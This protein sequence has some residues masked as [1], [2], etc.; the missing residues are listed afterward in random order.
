LHVRPLLFVACFAWVAC[1]ASL[2]AARSG[3][4]MV[5]GRV[6][7]L[8]PQAF[9]SLG[10][11]YL[12]GIEAGWVAPV[13]KKRLAISIDL[14]F[15]NPAADGH[16]ASAATAAPV[17]W[18]ASVRE[19]TIGLSLALRQAIGRF[20]PYL[21]VGPRLVIV[22]S[23]VGGSSGAARLPTS[24]EDSLALGVSIVPGL[25]F[26]L[27]P[28]QLF[29]EVPISLAWRVG[30]AP[31]LVGDFDPSFIGVTAGYRVFF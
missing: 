24:R 20:M 16:I 14:G 27:P 28:G 12:V 6:G 5:A 23:L 17:D 7:A 1:F 31:R 26:S 19:I 22:D 8:M 11:S 18:H 30:N 29:L 15:G 21:A 25:G 13:W 9:S 2:A 4:V 10:A 3:E